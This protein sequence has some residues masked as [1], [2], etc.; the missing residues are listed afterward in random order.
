MRIIKENKQEK[1]H[2]CDFCGS[3]IAYVQKG[4]YGSVVRYIKC[5]VCENHE[6]ISIFDK[7]IK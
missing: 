4:V 6:E 5:P 3:L 7:K 1:M 2:K